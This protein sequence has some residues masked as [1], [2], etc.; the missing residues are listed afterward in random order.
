[1]K[2]DVLGATDGYFHMQSTFLNKD[3]E[4]IADAVLTEEMG[5]NVEIFLAAHRKTPFLV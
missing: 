4:K 1:M 2:V 3:P 5:L